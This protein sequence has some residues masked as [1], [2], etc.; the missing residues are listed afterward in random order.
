MEEIMEGRMGVNRR[1][2][3]GRN[4]ENENER[5]KERKKPKES[6]G[7]IGQDG[8]RRRRRKKERKKEKKERKKEYRAQESE[9]QTHTRRYYMALYDVSQLECMTH[10]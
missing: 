1:G 3:A 10:T 2:K 9:I 8:R 6:E 5:T 4:N 7:W